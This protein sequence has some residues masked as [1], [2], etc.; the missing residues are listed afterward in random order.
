MP[1]SAIAVI[2]LP[3]QTVPPRGAIES[4]KTVVISE[5]AR[6]VGRERNSATI[7][8]HSASRVIS[9]YACFRFGRPYNLIRNNSI[10]S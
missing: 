9:L 5:P 1:K 4:P 8:L 10:P 7:T 2:R 6:N 3:S